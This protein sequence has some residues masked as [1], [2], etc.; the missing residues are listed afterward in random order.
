ME[1]GRR[2]LDTGAAA[3]YVGLSPSTL[4]RMRVEGGGP[5]YAKLGSRVV[6]DVHRLDAWTEAH[7]QRFAGRADG[8]GCRAR[9]GRRIPDAHPDGP[10][11]DATETGRRYLDTDAAAAYVGLGPSTLNRLRAVGGGPLYAKRGRRVLYDVQELDSW[12]AAHERGFTGE[13]DEP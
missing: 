6:Y 3:A 13:R 10:G 5:R 7:K 1:S 2:Y 9:D 12:I 8:R 4:N 11:T